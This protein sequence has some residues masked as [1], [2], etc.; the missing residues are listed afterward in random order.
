MNGTDP[1]FQGGASQGGPGMVHGLYPIIRRRRRPLV[2]P[3]F[4]A[5]KADQQKTGPRSTRIE[6]NGNRDGE[7][8]R[9]ELTSAATENKNEP[10]SEVT[11]S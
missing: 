8:A 4:T 5:D 3:D 2:D 7:L 11:E 6:A 1:A 9:A 10:A